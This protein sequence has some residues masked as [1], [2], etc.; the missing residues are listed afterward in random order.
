MSK[1]ER[2]AILDKQLAAELRPLLDELLD[3]LVVRGES[4]HAAGVVRLLVY[5]SSE[6]GVE[7]ALPGADTKTRPMFD[8]HAAGGIKQ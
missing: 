6:F 3:R 5:V 1:I 2:N 8:E 4:S 7:K